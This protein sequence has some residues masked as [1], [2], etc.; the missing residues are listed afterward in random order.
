MV[1]CWINTDDP[2]VADRMARAAVERNGWSVI[3]TD[4]AGPH[5]RAQE[6][7]G[8]VRYFDEAVAEGESCVFHTW[9]R[10]SLVEPDDND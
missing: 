2:D 10:I 7:E 4:H 6:S 1:N 9:P 3:K 5:A 8:G